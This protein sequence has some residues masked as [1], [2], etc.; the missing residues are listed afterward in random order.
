MMVDFMKFL[1]QFILAN[2]LL[3]YAHMKLVARGKTP[4]A[5]ALAFVS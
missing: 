1:A 2:F 3:H 5:N 4:E